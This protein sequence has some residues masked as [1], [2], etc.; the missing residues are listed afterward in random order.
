MGCRAEESSDAYTKFHAEMPCRRVLAR[1]A[2]MT[3]AR[4]ARQSVK[5]AR[6]WNRTDPAS[7][8][9]QM[10]AAEEAQRLAYTFRLIFD[11]KRRGLVQR[12]NWL[13][14]SVSDGVAS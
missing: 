13:E 3:V 10:K 14:N 2:I 11:A 6:G 5:A 12:D 9:N 7:L 4:A 1:Q 8:G